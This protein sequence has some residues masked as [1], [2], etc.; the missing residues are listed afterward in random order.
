[1]KKLFY[2]M[3]LCAAVFLSSC[4]NHFDINDVVGTYTFVE[5]GYLSIA[6]QT[7]EYSD[8]GTFTVSKSSGNRIVFKGD[9]TGNGTVL[10]DSNKLYI[11][12]DTNDFTSSDGIRWHFSHTYTNGYAFLNRLSWETIADVTASYNGNKFT[13]TYRTITTATKK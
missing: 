5:T 1:M 10:L 2:L 9:F 6:G 8:K 4:R 11:D 12:S 7:E 3:L 13:G